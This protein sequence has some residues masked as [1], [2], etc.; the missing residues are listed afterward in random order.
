MSSSLNASLLVAVLTLDAG[1]HVTKRPQEVLGRVPISGQ[2]MSLDRAA[3][4]PGPS[5]AGQH[6]HTRSSDQTPS[7]GVLTR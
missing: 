7:I 4:P 5:M 6:S 3:T 1:T 2:R